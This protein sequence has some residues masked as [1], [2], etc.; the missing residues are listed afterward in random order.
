MESTTTLYIG[1]LIAGIIAVGI[2]NSATTI[3]GVFPVN[4]SFLKD[5][6]KED[7][8][9]ILDNNCN[10]CHRKQNPFMIFNERNIS[11]R[12]NRIYQAVFVDRRMPKGDQF[13]LTQEEYKILKQ[14]LSNQNKL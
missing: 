13:T 7:V 6:L 2:Y 1:V 10:A 14:W 12:S 3:N 9:K 4:K 5:P 8:L 11:R